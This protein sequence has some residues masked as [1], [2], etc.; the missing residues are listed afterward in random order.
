MMKKISQEE[1]RSIDGG[2]NYCPVCIEKYG[3]YFENTVTHQLSFHYW[4][5][6]GTHSCC[7]EEH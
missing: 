5:F 1:A 4:E 3:L 2:V 6:V 7:A